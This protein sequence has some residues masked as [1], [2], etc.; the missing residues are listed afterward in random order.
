[1]GCWPVTPDEGIRT[2]LVTCTNGELGDGPGGIKPGEPGHDEAEVVALRRRGARGELRVLGGRRSGAARLRRLGDDGLAAERRARRLLA[3]PGRRAAAQLA[4][5]ME[6]YR[7]DVVVTYDENGFYGH[8]DHIQAHRITMA[9]AR[10]DRDPG[11]GLLHRAAPLIARRLCRR[12]AA[13]TG[14]SC[15]NRSRRTRSSARR[16][17]RSR[18]WSTAPSG[19]TASTTALAAHASQCDN[20]FFLQMGEEGF[21]R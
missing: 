14:S 20:I 1:M 9:A 4:E 13:S 8:P 18:R 6:R 5:L 2:V 3:H 7:P 12:A 15:P 11:Q 10:R 19:P 21:T 16:T 17:S